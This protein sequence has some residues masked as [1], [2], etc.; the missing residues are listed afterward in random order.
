LKPGGPFLGLG[1][2]GKILRGKEKRFQTTKTGK[3]VGTQERKGFSADRANGIRGL[4]KE[5][6]GYS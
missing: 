4:G 2:G 6:R 5:R 1:T 3:K